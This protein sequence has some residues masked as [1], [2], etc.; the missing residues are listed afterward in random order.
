MVFSLTGCKNKTETEESSEISVVD[1]ID[2][3]ELEDENLST[4]DDF[5]S[6]FADDEYEDY[7]DSDSEEEDDYTE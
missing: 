6:Y 3:E 2:E 1:N 4:D 7:D 5:E